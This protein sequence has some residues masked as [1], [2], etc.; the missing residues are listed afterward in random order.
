MIRRSGAKIPPRLD[1]GGSIGTVLI[2]SK[3][4]KAISGVNDS[5]IDPGP[6][7]IESPAVKAGNAGRPKAEN[8]G[9][10]CVLELVANPFA[11]GQQGCS[12][13]CSDET[14]WDHCQ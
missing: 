11:E 9:M 5:A 10:D 1:V 4:C 2:C 3:N 7:S 8:L 14:G 13:N 6:F 12:A